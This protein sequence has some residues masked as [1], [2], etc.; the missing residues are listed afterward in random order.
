MG[1]KWHAVRRDATG[2]CSV[3]VRRASVVYCERRD[4]AY[5]LCGTRPKQRTNKTRAGRPSN[6]FEKIAEPAILDTLDICSFDNKLQILALYSL[7]QGIKH[8]LM[9]MTKLSSFEL[10]ASTIWDM[11]DAHSMLPG[12]MRSYVK[13]IL[14]PERLAS[15]MQV[16]RKQNNEM[17]NKCS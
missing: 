15:N 13:C 7:I 10:S 16:I 5:V 8:T 2:A 1:E 11:V 6:G 3:G 12:T 14:N 17:K 9:V 4:W